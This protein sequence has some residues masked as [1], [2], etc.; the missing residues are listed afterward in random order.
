MNN[1]VMTNLSKRDRAFQ[2]KPTVIPPFFISSKGCPSVRDKPDDL[3]LSGIS[4]S[5]SSDMLYLKMKLLVSDL[6]GWTPFNINFGMPQPPS[7]LC[8]L[9]VIEASPTEISTVHHILES[10]I[11]KADQLECES[12]MV[13]FDQAIYSKAQQIRWK[14]PIFHD[15]LVLR[16]GEFHTC[17]CFLS[18]IGKRFAMSGLEDILVESGTI[19]GGSM[20]GVISGHMY[21]RSIRAHKLL[22]EALGRLQLEAF[23]CLR[24]LF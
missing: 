23:F 20:K 7:T 13:V 22:F 11:E 1:V 15:R 21:N 10:A 5:M 6:P 8:Y 24:L 12:I 18:V 17:M 2:S 3:G 16:T 19:A 14:S 4:S 9:P